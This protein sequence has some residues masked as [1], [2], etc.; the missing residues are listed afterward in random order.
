VHRGIF[1]SKKRPIQFNEVGCISEDNKGKEEK[2]T[3]TAQ[4]FKSASTKQR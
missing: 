3:V 1:E 2:L 4:E